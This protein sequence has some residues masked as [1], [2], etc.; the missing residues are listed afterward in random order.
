M[1]QKERNRLRENVRLTV[2]SF[3]NRNE[4]RAYYVQPIY[5]NTIQSDNIVLDI[6]E[7]NEEG[8]QVRRNRRESVDYI[9]P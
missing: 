7:Y 3:S 1:N 6:L 8:S 4:V 5:V 9:V 2:N